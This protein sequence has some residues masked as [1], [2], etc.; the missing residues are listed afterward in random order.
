MN[1][2]SFAMLVAGLLLLGLA[3]DAGV[4]APTTVDTTHS[5]AFADVV[6][7]D[8]D[9]VIDQYCTRCHSEQR[10]RGGLVLEGFSVE[11]AAQ[12]ADIA[13]RMIKKLR[14]GMMP[15]SGARRPE[16]SALSD[17]AM[18][19]ESRI[20][21]EWRKNPEPGTR[22]F[23]RLN[24]AEYAASVEHLLGLGVDVSSFLPLDT[25]SANFDNIADVQMPSTTVV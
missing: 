13:E 6:A 11:A 5:M 1:A 16:G 12:N 9:E 20:D 15:P 24:Q 17:L 14:A 18:E 10:Q 22:V 8:G 19:L 7:L 23:Q 2:S 21:E 4:D 3:G 25:K